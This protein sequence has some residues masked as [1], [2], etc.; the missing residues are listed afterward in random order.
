MTS[1][2]KAK[3]A[4]AGEGLDEFKA[5]VRAYVPPPSRE[6][7][8]AK[9]RAAIPPSDWTLVFDTE[10]TVDETQ[11]LRFGAYQLRRKGELVELGLF[12]DPEG[13][14]L[15]ERELL[16]K[17][18]VSKGAV[19]MARDKFVEEVFFGKAYEL[20]ALIVGYNLPFDLSRIAIAHDSARGKM[21]GGYTL[22]LSANQRR[23]RV[24]VRH[25]N[26]RA[27]LIQFALPR[28]QRTVRGARKRG[29][30]TPGR[31]GTF[32]DVRTIAAALLSLR[33][34][35]GSLADHLET[36]SRKQEVETHGGLLTAQYIEYALQD[37]Q[38]TW[39]C[40][41]KLINR[42]A[43]HGLSQTISKILSEASLGKAYLSE[44]GVRSFQSVQPD[45]PKPL[46]GFILSAYFGGRCEVRWR[47][48][49]KQVLSCDFLSMYPTICTLMKL[50]RFVIAKGVD[51]R[52]TTLAT[53]HFL[54][55]VTL[56][57]LQRQK[58]WERLHTLV[59]LQ[60]NEDVL[61]LR[62]KYDRIS[63]TIGLN[64]IT[65]DHALWYTLADVIVSKL[66]TGRAPRIIKAISF[67]PREPQEGL[68]PIR[69]GGAEGEL[70]DPYTDDLYRRLIDIRSDIKARMA[71]AADRDLARLDSEQQAAKILANATSYGT[72]VEVNATGLAEAETRS[73]FG[74]DASSFE[75]QTRK[76]EEPGP[77]FHPLIATLITGGARLMLGMAESL[78]SEAGLDWAFC[79]TDSMA[80]AKP[81][82]M[83]SAEFFD[84]ARAIAGAFDMLNPYARPGPLLKVEGEN[85]GIGDDKQLRPLYAFCISSKRYVLFNVAEDGSPVIRKA[86]AHGL[87]HLRAPYPASAAPKSVPSP[88]V[89]LEKI[90]VERWHYDLWYQ[91]IK[92][93]LAGHSAE[94]DLAYHPNNSFPAMSRYAATTPEILRWMK[95]RNA[96]KSYRDQ[97]K[98]FGFLSAF[99]ARQDWTVANSNPPSSRRT[100]RLAKPIAPF[101]KDPCEAGGRSFDRETGEPIEAAILK[102]YALALAQY[103][104]SPESKFLNGDRWD[105]GRTER[106]RLR[107]TG[108]NHIG[109]EA[110]NL[111]KQ[112][113][114][115]FE[116]N[117]QIE[118]GGSPAISLEAHLKTLCER[119]GEREA[120]RRAGVSRMSLRKARQN[121]N[122]V[123]LR[124]MQRLSRL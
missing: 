91:I 92:A 53:Q 49:I 73:C 20:R 50:W 56:S 23:P 43:E 108:V 28:L 123:R 86:S 25:L 74:P 101:S 22:L 60:P 109:K 33:G 2:R 110:N 78:A 93:A 18:A 82:A 8:A 63:P 62:A 21:K 76:S 52:E 44:M 51:W 40:F 38:V 71:T 89:P 100:S 31:R 121:I 24:Q 12:Y 81:D 90:G 122:S 72:F 98:P 115:G 26:G 27:A 96:G 37:V 114:L 119:L 54:D 55:E 45:F 97:V 83:P 29:L 88:L 79:D 69:V 103:H 95:G 113:F 59:Q 106:R 36:S 6:P 65:S 116:K 67:E 47:R 85:F 105:H 111:E 1:G 15:N 3:L 30:P 5:M 7:R 120:A 16:K 104:L 99:Q 57:D 39:E 124:T 58:T 35:L 32:V 19:F 9:G 84:K 66:R 41:E 77:F 94:V 102:S 10:T 11:S 64:E 17:V 46:L 112:F 4:H 48:E 42:F 61:P 14:S 117:E 70:I 118:Y 107:V 87:G 13:M 80:F 34:N 68:M 75:V